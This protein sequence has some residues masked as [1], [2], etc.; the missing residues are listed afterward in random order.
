MSD[1]ETD[2]AN[3]L[4]N[5]SFLPGC[6]DKRFVRNLNTAKPMTEKGR[7]FMVVL[8]FKYR[9]QIPNHTIFQ[10]RLQNG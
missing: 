8:L 2:I 4:K 1:I 6:F 7:K 10:T 9:K 5:C 3:A